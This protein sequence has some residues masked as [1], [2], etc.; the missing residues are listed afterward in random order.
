MKILIVMENRKQDTNTDGIET[1]LARSHPPTI[2]TNTRERSS[3]PQLILRL[4]L[5]RLSIRASTEF[6]GTG[7]RDFGVSGNPEF[8]GAKFYFSIFPKCNG[9]E[10]VTPFRGS[11]RFVN[12]AR[13]PVLDNPVS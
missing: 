1:P 10:T 13:L 2:P 11:K 12:L 7:C 8:T 9:M 5:G 6:L 4:R 3:S